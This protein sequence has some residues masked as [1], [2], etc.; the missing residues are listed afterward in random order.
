MLDEAEVEAAA[1]CRQRAAAGLARGPARAQHGRRTGRMG[2]RRPDGGR[3]TPPRFLAATRERSPTSDSVAPGSRTRG[4]SWQRWR[5]RGPTVDGPRRALARPVRRAGRQGCVAVSGLART[6]GAVLV[7]AE[8]LPHRAALV[9][10]AS[11]GLPRSQARRRGRRAAAG[12][13]SGDVRPG[14]R[15]RSVYRARCAAPSARVALASPAGRRTEPRRC[16]S[17]SFSTSARGVGAAGRGG[18]LRD[19]LAAPRGDAWRGRRR[20]GSGVATW[21]SWTPRRCC[22][23]SPGPTRARAGQCSCGRI[24]TAPTRCSSASV[25]R[26]DR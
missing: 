6:E 1:G 5:C 3:R 16:C 19:L 9:R 20:A 25:R 22:L 11:A 13:A 21:S 8:R 26:L 18:R 2:S 10:S 7:A 14:D 12:L 24:G 23:N 15:R 17:A 4:R